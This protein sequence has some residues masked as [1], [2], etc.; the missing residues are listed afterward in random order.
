[1]S[2]ALTGLIAIVA[3]FTIFGSLQ[4]P[5]S[6]PE[7]PAAASTAAASERVRSELAAQIARRPD[8]PQRSVVVRD[9]VV[10]VPYGPKDPADYREWV[11]GLGY[12]YDGIVGTGLDY[13]ADQPGVPSLTE[14]EATKKEV[15]EALRPSATQAK[16]GW[17]V[18]ISILDGVVRVTHTTTKNQELLD[19]LTRVKNT[20]G[21]MVAIVAEEGPIS[22]AVTTEKIG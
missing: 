4:P 12:T 5:P 1:M 15:T 19:A 22:P 8:W 16:V 7:R 17:G 13:I 2:A 18:S 10:W 11:A 14:L 9:D 3:G 6:P 21:A 20:H